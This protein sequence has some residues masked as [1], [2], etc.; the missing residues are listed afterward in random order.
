MISNLDL[1]IPSQLTLALVPDLVLMGG[2]MLLL[3]WAAVRPESDRHQRA[4][5]DR[6]LQGVQEGRVNLRFTLAPCGDFEA[7]AGRPGFVLLN[8]CGFR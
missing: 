3:V 8:H 4:A 1:A 7:R 2:A 6:R 5:Q